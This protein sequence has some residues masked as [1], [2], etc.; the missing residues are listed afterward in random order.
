MV[1]LLVEGDTLTEETIKEI[2]IPPQPTSEPSI[3][4]KIET[5]F[6]EAL[7]SIKGYAAEP[8]I[9]KRKIEP[10]STKRDFRSNIPRDINDSFQSITNQ[11]KSELSRNERMQ[12]LVRRKK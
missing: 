8:T 11:K 5:Q 2:T 1:S 12:F 10:F 7:S 6:K 3:K 9:A 4:E